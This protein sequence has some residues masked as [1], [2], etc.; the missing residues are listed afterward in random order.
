MSYT[1]LTSG[2]RSDTLGANGGTTG[3]VDTSGAN[4]IVL[5]VAAY[6]GVTLAA[7]DIS[8]NKSNTS[9]VLAGGAT[10]GPDATRIHT[11]YHLTPS[12]GT[13]HTFTVTKTSSFCSSAVASFSGAHTSP[14]LSQDGGNATSTSVL[15][16]TGVTPSE[17]DCL[18]VSALADNDGGT[19]T[20]PAGFTRT[21]RQ[22]KDPG[23]AYGIA[24][25][26]M[27]Q[28]AAAL[29][30][31]S[32]TSASSVELATQVVAFKSAVVAGAKPAGY[33][34][35]RFSRPLGA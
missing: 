21:N 31:P 22:V 1:Y 16:V 27:I 10:Y 26:Y 3:I 2:H 28:G 8:D 24:L 34:Y 7:G 35:S 29:A 11:F 25:A 19:L 32:W 12:V 13:G 20:D 4:L 5:A 6:T 33:Y 18:V 17:A 15:P 23:N 9:W 30:R 14:Y